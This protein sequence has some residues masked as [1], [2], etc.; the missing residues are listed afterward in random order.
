[1]STLSAVIAGHECFRAALSA[2]AHPGR[3]FPL[4]GAVDSEVAACALIQSLYEPDMPICCEGDWALPVA[5]HRVPAEQARVLLVRGPTSGGGLARAPRGSEEHPSHGATVLYVAS[6]ESA[7]VTDVQLRGPGVDG[8]LSTSLALT[9][10][11]LADRAAACERR[12]L[13]VDLLLVGADGSVTGLPRSTR[14]EV[15]G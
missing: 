8:L 9:A 6:G 4:A 2:L 1:M 7:S 5:H 14:V 13:G 12:P 3:R 10:A 11:E 15:V